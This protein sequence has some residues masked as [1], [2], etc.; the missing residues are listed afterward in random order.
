MYAEGIQMCD[1][2]RR[3]LALL[4]L[5]GALVGA[6]LGALLLRDRVT[7][8]SALSRD[9]FLREIKM[10]ANMPV[11][12]AS[13]DLNRRFA[14]VVR[15]DDS[16][17]TL[18]TK[19]QAEVFIPDKYSMAA[20]S[21]TTGEPEFSRMINT[22]GRTWFR[23]T[24]SQVVTQTI[25]P[26]VVGA[27]VIEGS[28]YRCR[29]G[30]SKVDIEASG[31]KVKLPLQEVGPGMIAVRKSTSV[32]AYPAA[33]A[34][35][36]V[37]FLLMIFVPT[38][39]LSVVKAIV[40]AAQSPGGSGRPFRY[41]VMY[42]AVTTLLAGLI[43]A[44]AGY[45]CYASQS[46]RTDLGDIA[47]R[48]LGSKAET[49]DYEAH[50][51]LTQ[52]VGIVPTNPLSALSSPE[53]NRG[54]QVAFTAILIGI[55]LALMGPEHRD[56]VAQLLKHVL[57]LIVKDTDL[58]WRALS[59]WADL[60]T[61]LGVFF[62]SMNFFATVNYDF[63]REMGYVVLSILTA[64]AFHALVLLIWTIA[65]R[66]WRNWFSSGLVPGIPGLLTAMATSSS[67][68]ALPGIAR[69]PLLA[70]DSSRRGVF[71]LC[72]TINKNG[73]TIYIATVASYVLF[74]Q[75]HNSASSI[76][77]LVLLSSLASVATAGLPFAA[78]FGLR[79]VLMAAGSPG[80]L[81]WAIFP[82]DPLVDRFVTVLNV[83]SNLAACS[84]R[85]HNAVSIVLEPVQPA[86][87]GGA[88]A[89]A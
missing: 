85:K 43:G 8:S 52:L 3:N 26:N 23:G 65:K 58:N 53:G 37:A 25:G 2:I 4:T 33:I 62:V 39:T 28:L 86:P 78:I 17:S 31:I 75:L 79:I 76:A 48:S 30:D 66:D 13:R 84:D 11:I 18:D 69:V 64:L 87:T 19:D 9:E 6:V 47:A 29:N 49:L 71:D 70:R 7:H 51:V 82:I 27:V 15:G 24:V 16:Q 67:Y 1:V 88:A 59:D 20:I 57:A 12:A 46:K 40:D 68:A 74:C 72:T 77:L 61:P 73:T 34:D 42:F 35:L 38:L 41:S 63:M 14:E 83:F 50:P 21:C 89:E 80:S 54:L 55:L 45:F 32:T 56:R 81:A 44:T 22:H 60:L 5:L 36:F 10:G